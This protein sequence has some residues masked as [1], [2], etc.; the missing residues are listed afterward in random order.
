MLKTLLPNFCLQRFNAIFFTTSLSFRRYFVLLAKY[1][2]ILPVLWSSF[3]YASPNTPH[4]L[5]TSIQIYTPTASH[6]L[7]QKT[8]NSVY[9]DNIGL[10]W[11]G[12][13]SGIFRWDGNNLDSFEDKSLNGL[14]LSTSHIS[15]ILSDKN[16][17]LWIL[18]RHNGIFYR[19]LDSPEFQLVSEKE[20]ELQDDEISA[21]AVDN[22][23]ASIWIISAHGKIVRFSPR[24]GL[25][26][27]CYLKTNENGN[28]EFRDILMWDNHLWI[29]S[30]Q[31]LLRVPTLDDKSNCDNTRIKVFPDVERI[32]LLTTSSLGEKL[33][34][35]SSYKLGY[36]SSYSHQ[37]VM[38]KNWL[39]HSQEFD[40]IFDLAIT[41]EF[42]LIATD[43]GIYRLTDNGELLQRINYEN[44]NLANNTVIDFHQSNNVVYAGTYHGLN[45][46][47][48][49]PFHSVNTRNS[50]VHD[51]VMT[52]SSSMDGQLFIGTY[53][54]LFQSDTFSPLPY[55]TSFRSIS[56]LH[57]KRISA[58]Q[59]SGNQLYVGY[60]RE[61]LELVNMYD[62][63]K[64]LP[65]SS[66]SKNS[67]ITDLFSRTPSGLWVSTNN[68]GLY[69]LKPDG[70]TARYW[71]GGIN[72]F[73]LPVDAIYGFY[74]STSG[75]RYIA[76]DDDLMVQDSPQSMFRPVQTWEN[77]KN[78]YLN[79]PKIL[80]IAEDREGNVWLG[81]LNRGL[82][83]KQSPVYNSENSQAIAPFLRSTLSTV[84]TIYT[85]E[86]DNNDNL[87]LST[88]SGI[89]RISADRKRVDNFGV[90]DGLLTTEF[91]FGASH[92][93]SEGNLYFGG[94]KG[95]VQFN[96][97]QVRKN[98]DPSPVI[99]SDIITPDGA[100]SDKTL[101]ARVSSIELDPE[102]YFITF[103]FSV[104]DFI[105]PENHRFRY[106]LE[107][108]DPDWRESGKHNSA[109]Y[110]NLPPGQYSLK[111]LGK[112][113]TGVWSTV[114]TEVD[115]YVLP[116]FSQTYWA[117]LIYAL[118]LLILSWV[119]KHVYRVHVLK[120]HAEQRFE[121]SRIELEDTTDRLQASSE[122][123]RAILLN[124]QNHNIGNLE[125]A[126]TIARFNN[127]SLLPADIIDGSDSTS[128]RINA[129]KKLESHLYQRGAEL[130]A[131]FHTYINDLID[132]LL[133]TSGLDPAKTVTTN[134]VSDKL[135]PSETASP[136]SLIAYELLHNAFE[137]AFIE[138]QPAQYIFVTLELVRD[139][140]EKRWKFEVSDNGCGLP[141]DISFEH[142]TTAGFNIVH[143]TLAKMNWRHDV[144]GENGTTIT[145]WI[146]FGEEDSVD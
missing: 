136:L 101:P 79:P 14:K 30:N 19:T 33:W 35:V 63:S 134:A 142:A 140:G 10:I 43:S 118:A 27:F 82:F 36:F 95:Y 71:S 76:T 16:E 107:G 52:L 121:E 73:N 112:N 89:T 129:L 8:I 138:E 96:P 83:Y 109:T 37:N 45:I 145:I 90:A 55:D 119:T 137:H 11:I 77:S 141:D 126:E 25:T 58:I 127:V 80:S 28:P 123:R 91:N 102:D 42:I 75:V 29:I 18:T 2:A 32:S 1:I 49:S 5:Q 51:E 67:G 144:S 131:D 120:N 115:I 17:T 105:A 12:T 128:A 110:T 39:P 23:D 117:Y 132:S 57:G 59:A 48:S 69:N 130:R 133:K 61:G 135:I 111:V 60:L 50:I 98:R 113:S 56:N 22:Q 44:S 74:E 38:I 106:Q 81:S 93:D 68:H 66:I 64:A 47:I 6:N 24:V 54:G 104:L 15:S 72:E 146:P 26:N 139:N 100:V 103:V 13:Q 114:P 9:V 34:F 92:K 108:F 84:K 97:S 125:H 99:I 4:N 124:I 143:S 86:T 65:V 85:I 62:L 20:L 116:K 21:I 53:E 94:S 40:L 78:S 41:G 31:S 87:W 7:P 3:I 46:L 70:T 122:L 88:N